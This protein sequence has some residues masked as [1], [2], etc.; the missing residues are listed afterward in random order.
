MNLLFL[1]FVCDAVDFYVA[2]FSSID[3]LVGD[4]DS[5]G[6]VD[7]LFQTRRIHLTRT[8]FLLLLIQTSDSQARAHYVPVN[9]YHRTVSTG[10]G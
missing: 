9:S 2:A 5:I 10:G 7:P 3:E 6:R 8:L 4:V 1:Q